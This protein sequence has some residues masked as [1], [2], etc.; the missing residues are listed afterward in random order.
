MSNGAIIFPRIGSESEEGVCFSDLATYFHG[1][2]KIIES[3]AAAALP[4]DESEITERVNAIRLK[5]DH[6]QCDNMTNNKLGDKG[7]RKSM[8]WCH[9][10]LNISLVIFRY[11]REKVR[12]LRCETIEQYI[13]IFDDLKN[14]YHHVYC[15]TDG[16]YHFDD[17]N[18]TG[19]TYRHY[20]EFFNL[21]LEPESRARE[22]SNRYDLCSNHIYH[23]ITPS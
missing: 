19:S 12:R 2:L 17:S 5:N 13:K 11:E 6:F 18:C 20:V 4:Q 21:Q 22:S 23:Y 15:K 10:D 16:K 7:E 1:W 8:N 14:L 3:I 9:R